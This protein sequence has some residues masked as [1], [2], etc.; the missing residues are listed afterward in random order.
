MS[1]LEK[2]SSRRFQRA[3]AFGLHRWTSLGKLMR[4]L[5]KKNQF[6]RRPAPCVAL[7][8]AVARHKP[9]P[10]AGV[11]AITILAITI[12]AIATLTIPILAITMLGITI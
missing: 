4:S 9:A 10:R 8:A 12:S 7:A 2:P 1:P 11:L 5:R 3:P 6:W